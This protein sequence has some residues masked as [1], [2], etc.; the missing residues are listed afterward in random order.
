MLIQSHAGYIEI[1][2]AIPKAWNDVSFHQLRTEGA[3]LVRADMKD[4]KI[5]S[6]KVKAEKGGL[7]Q[8]KL[9]AE[10]FNYNVKGN[11]ATPQITDRMLSTSMSV[12]SE[13]NLQPIY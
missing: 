13:L 5:I 4:G 12:G 8:L 1:L 11:V 9:P 7:L 10:K 2:P 6:I 3:F